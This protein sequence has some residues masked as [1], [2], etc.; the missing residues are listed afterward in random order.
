MAL[1]DN[2][3]PFSA[4]AENYERP[5][6]IRNL[7][8]AIARGE[9]LPDDGV[10]VDADVFEAPYAVRLISPQRSSTQDET[11]VVELEVLK[12]NADLVILRSNI[13]STGW[14]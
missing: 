1:S 8:D 3:V 9:A 5:G 13:R 11:Y 10:D 6:L 4:L 2:Y 12:D 7:L 14:C